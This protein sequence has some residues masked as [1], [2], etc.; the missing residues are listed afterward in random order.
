MIRR[1]RHLAPVIACALALA[2]CSAARGDRDASSRLPA[3]SLS[4][5]ASARTPGADKRGSLGPAAWPGYHF[6]NART[7]A[8]GSGPALSPPTRAWT[9]DLGA[10]VRGQAVVADGRIIAAT[11]RNRI[12]A[13]DP[14]DGSV[15]WSTTFGR[16][17]TD[18]T[19]RA[20]C[21]N[22]DP[23]GV[24][25][26]PVIDVPRHTVYVVAEL[27]DGD[28]VHHQLF[29]I[30]LATGRIRLSKLA[31]PPLPA[32]EKAIHLLQRAG[33]AI[34][35]GR[36]YVPYGGNIGDCGTYHGWVVGVDVA[37]NRLN[38]AFNVTPDGQ[39]GAIWSGGGAP[40]V[41]QSG[42]VFV[43]TGNANP[44]PSGKDPL[45]W[46]ESVVK[47]APDLRVLGAYK[48]P[49]AGG[50]EDLATGNPVLLPDGTVFAV[51]KTDIGWFLRQSDLSVLASV[52]DVCGSDPDGGPAYDARTGRLFVPCRGGGIQVIDAVRHRLGPRL[53]GADSAPIIV[54]DRLWAVNTGSGEL[55]SY[56]VATLKRGATVQVADSLSVFTSPSAGLGLLL[57]GTKSGVAAFR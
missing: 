46:A 14:T 30:D 43:S 12:V 4:E 23:L 26:T 19:S 47:L 13:L 53:D 40:A 5:A 29:G 34:A 10:P 18:V 49:E 32:G 25:S 27:D 16:P 17:L 42:N 39:G 7:G 55:T 44:F 11:E 20:G 8:V 51:G 37:G 48:D 28:A 3:A 1:T 52:R 6:D 57:V 56:D 36:V 35:G 41:D 33:L 38:A 2:G 21:G 31:D 22:I 45:R 54:G 15:L 50:D 24:T 9:A